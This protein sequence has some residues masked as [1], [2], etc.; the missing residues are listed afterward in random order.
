MEGANFEVLRATR[1]DPTLNFNRP[2]G[3]LTLFP[4]RNRGCRS[5]QFRTAVA[6]KNANDLGVEPGQALMFR[7]RMD[8][9]KIYGLE[10]E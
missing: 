2:D 10:F 1:T 8:K 9:A 5:H 4:R 6:W 3:S 7:F